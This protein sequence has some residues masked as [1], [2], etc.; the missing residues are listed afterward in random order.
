VGIIRN[1]LKIHAARKNARVFLQIQKEFGTFS[2]YLWR[3]V[4]NKPI[5]NEWQL[6]DEMPVK[7]EISDALSKDLKKRGMSFVGTTI[8]YA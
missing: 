6:L 8:T 1:W 4:A 2:S 7:T 3:Y 5:I